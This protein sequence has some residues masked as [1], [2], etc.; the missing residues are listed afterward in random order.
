VRWLTLVAPELTQRKY[1]TALSRDRLWRA[2]SVDTNLRENLL[3]QGRSAIFHVL[4]LVCRCGCHMHMFR[5]IDYLTDFD[6]SG[7][8]PRWESGGMVGVSKQKKICRLPYIVLTQ[9]SISVLLQEIE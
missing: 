3:V 2:L 4:L 7:R 1:G 6:V 9:S 5:A 8:I